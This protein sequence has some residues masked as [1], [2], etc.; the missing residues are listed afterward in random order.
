LERFVPHFTESFFIEAM[1]ILDSQNIAN[2][3][4]D[5]VSVE[6]VEVLK[7]YGEI[8]DEIG[9]RVDESVEQIRLLKLKREEAK[10]SKDIAT[11]RETKKEIEQLKEE[12]SSD[13][14]LFEAFLERFGIDEFD[15]EDGELWDLL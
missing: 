8:E 6:P 11:L 4:K 12:I 13:K 1:V 9:E 14:E 15:F 2:T 7:Y 3:P 5:L 10:I